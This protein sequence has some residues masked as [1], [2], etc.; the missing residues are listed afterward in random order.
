MD[1]LIKVIILGIVEGITEF[2]PISSTGHLLIASQLLNAEVAERLGGTF[3]IFIQLGAVVAVIGYYRRD[4]WRQARTVTSDPDVRRLWLAIVIAAIPAGVAGLLLRDFLK[5]EVFTSDSRGLVIAV[6]LILGGFV[7][8]IIERSPRLTSQ[9][10][11][12][13]LS[14]VTYR[15]ALWIGIAQVFALVP[16]VSRSGASIVGGMLSGQTRQ[17]ATAFSFYLS[18]PVLGGATILDLLLSLN[19]V[20]SQDILYLTLGAIVSCVVAWIAIGWL[21]R[22]ISRNS[23]IPFG[24]YRIGAGCVILLLIVSNIL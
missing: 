6:A 3:E 8:L 24:Y 16:G 13:D 17:V 18:I 15:Q 19:E 9:T 11:T 12:A 1:E 2:L 22:Y 23:F 10:T 7:F 20:S 5:E 21:L 4:L 14:A